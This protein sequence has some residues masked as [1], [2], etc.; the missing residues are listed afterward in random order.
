MIEI[1]SLLCDYLYVSDIFRLS[2]ALSYHHC[3][4]PPA[5]IHLVRRTLAVPPR[6]TLHNFMIT[7]MSRARCRQ[8]GTTC[9]SQYPRY[10][11][12]CTR[13]DTNSPMLMVDRAYIMHHYKGKERRYILSSISV[14]RRGG[15]RAHLFRM[16]DV[17]RLSLHFVE[18]HGK[19]TP[20]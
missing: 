10:C 20:T 4:W 19:Q 18:R 3:T 8:C 9:Y 16:S 17:R 12:Q 5:D 7:Y 11:R 2:H 13:F 6:V 15:N 1:F 14:E